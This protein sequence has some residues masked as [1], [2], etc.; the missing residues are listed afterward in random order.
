MKIKV[1][2]FAMYRK[3]TEKLKGNKIIEVA[4]GTTPRDIFEFLGVPENMPK[5]I[6]VNGRPQPENYILKDGDHLVFF[7]PLEGG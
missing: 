4:D 3:Y 7:P 1:E 2:S 6:L 5:I